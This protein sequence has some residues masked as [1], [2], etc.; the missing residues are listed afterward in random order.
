VAYFGEPSRLNYIYRIEKEEWLAS[1]ATT[2]WLS[3]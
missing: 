3:C 1:K 2:V